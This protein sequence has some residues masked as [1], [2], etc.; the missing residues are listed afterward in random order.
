MNK[1]KNKVSDSLI[2]VKESEVMKQKER[3]I[4]SWTPEEDAVLRE[5]IMLHGT[6][7]KW[8]II[9]SKLEGK[10]I[11][12]CKR[13]WYSYLNSDFKKG[14]WSN[15]EDMLLCE[16]QKFYGNRWTEIAKVVSGRT[17]N[18]VKNRFST[19]CKKRAK[20]NNNGF[21]AALK[22]TRADIS[23]TSGPAFVENQINQT[24][25]NVIPLSGVGYM[26]TTSPVRPPFAELDQN[27]QTGANP[28]LVQQQD[29][30]E[31][32]VNTNDDGDKIQ[33]TFLEQNDPV[34]LALMQ[35]QE[36]LRSLVVEVNSEDTYQ[37]LDNG[38]Q[39]FQDYHNQSNECDPA[40]MVNSYSMS[41][42]E[43]YMGSVED[44]TSDEF[45]Q[46][47]LRPPD[48]HMNSPG[49]SA[50]STGSTM[51]TQPDQ[52]RRR[53][54]IKLQPTSAS[55][56]TGNGNMMT[57]DCPPSSNEV[58]YFQAPES[59]QA[60]EILKGIQT[61]IEFTSPTRLTPLLRTLAEEVP[62]PAFSESEKRFLIKTFDL[63]SP[64]PNKSANCSKF[65]TCKRVLLPSL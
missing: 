58:G 56:D 57:M 48:L 28:L 36:L 39:V 29:I 19:L 44:L 13:R 64:S 46:P 23:S 61:D 20:E 59:I 14:E 9:A 33:D 42:I 21:S 43:K 31:A 35:E 37:S 26:N 6:D 38:W 32:G 3:H 8:R 52:E 47:S 17:D 55:G 11:R 4:V 5:Q 24:K 60:D 62:T 34:I 49:S 25:P 65:P 7:K 22:K 12:Q 63:E 18:A 50:Y 10:T 30:N 54:E 40:T 45:D 16:A 53:T 27:L 41:D 51:L 2:N 1:M 15:E